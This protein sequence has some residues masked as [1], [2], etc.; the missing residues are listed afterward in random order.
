VRG[1]VTLALDGVNMNVYSLPSTSVEFFIISQDTKA[2]SWE[3]CEVIN[4][5]KTSVDLVVSLSEPCI[6]Y[7]VI[8]LK[9]TEFPTLEDF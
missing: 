3:T 2:P 4:I 1:Y 5:K 7:Y 6:V 9:G 8:A